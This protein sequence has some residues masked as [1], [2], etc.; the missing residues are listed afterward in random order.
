MPHSSSK[1]V[2]ST[3]HARLRR[4]FQNRSCSHPPEPVAR[5]VAVRGLCKAWRDRARAFANRRRS[6]GARRAEAYGLLWEWVAPARPPSERLT[7]ISYPS[8]S[9]SR[10]RSRSHSSFHPAAAAAAH[11][12]ALRRLRQHAHTQPVAPLRNRRVSCCACSAL[13]LYKT[14]MRS[15][16]P[17]P[18]PP[19]SARAVRSHGAAASVCARVANAATDGAGQMV[20]YAPSDY[21]DHASDEF[22]L[23][24]IKVERADA[25]EWCALELADSA[26]AAGAIADSAS[27]SAGSSL[28]GGS[29]WP[30]FAS[31]D[32]EE[33]DSIEIVDMSE[34]EDDLIEPDATADTATSVPEQ[35]VAENAW[36]ALQ[37][38]LSDWLGRLPICQNADPTVVSGVIRALV[39]SEASLSILSDFAVSE[40]VEIG[41]PA[42][43]ARGIH[44]ALVVTPTDPQ[45][46]LNHAS[47]ARTQSSPKRHAVHSGE[48]DP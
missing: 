11:T 35:L 26:A 32:A 46:N 5:S 42:D 10:F 17:A 9:R 8:R 31:H 36:P 33:D 45:V 30:A 43:F 28:N 21:T 12:L 4:N 41:I 2:I 37:R 48:R 1:N 29:D 47:H 44:D 7:A 24:R 3:V 23:T 18:Y 14:Q 22:G 34:S 25:H 40:L 13:G 27:V 6:A 39:A 19:W 16:L 20:V 38:E 15:A